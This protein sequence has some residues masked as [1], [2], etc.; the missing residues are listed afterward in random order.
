MLKCAQKTTC[1]VFPQ[2]FYP[3]FLIF[4]H[5]Y[6]CHTCDIIQLCTGVL[7]W[8][9]CDNVIYNRH[10]D[11][12]EVLMWHQCDNVIHTRQCDIKEVSSRWRLTGIRIKIKKNRPWSKIFNFTHLTSAYDF[13]CCIFQV[14]NNCEENPP[15]V[16]MVWL[17]GSWWA[18]KVGRLSGEVCRLRIKIKMSEKLLCV[19]FSLGKPAPA[20][21]PSPLGGIV[22]SD[23]WGRMLFSN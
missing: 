12:T 11:I 5:R 15:R 9:Q 3:N 6:I 13:C 1:F 17:G 2:T 20:S 21:R 14:T 23:L 22:R 18:K 10:G 8:H 7:M 19:N 4:L 16:R